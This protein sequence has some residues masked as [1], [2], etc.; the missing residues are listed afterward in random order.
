MRTILSCLLLL[1]TFAVQAQVNIKSFHSDLAQL[2]DLIYAGRFEV[3][4]AQY[5][6]FLRDL[7]V[8]GRLDDY[9]LA[10]VDSS[11]WATANMSNEP[12]VVYYH[13]HE[14]YAKYPVVNISLQG[15]TLYCEWLTAQYNQHPK[16]RFTEVLVRL[17]TA[18]EWEWAAR[19]GAEDAVYPWEGKEIYTP[20]GAPA[21]NFLL[22]GGDQ[23]LGVAGALS[24][25][26]DITAPVHSYSPNKAGLYNMAGNVAE[27][28]SDEA[29][30]KGGSW[31]NGAEYLRIDHKAEYHGEP[32]THVGFRFFV[33]VIEP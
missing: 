11:Q 13:T 23:S 22:E 24:D 25:N 19:A 26:A 17:P 2:D 7:K 16:R 33:D 3:T 20:K 18:Q 21:A 28:V 29:V 32:M 4:N 15:A 1:A 27:M 31:L 8:Q 10:R 5:A 14:A 12:F 30:A 6:D 9:A